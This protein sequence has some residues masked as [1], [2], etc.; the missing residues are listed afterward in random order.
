VEFTTAGKEIKQ[1]NP[2]TTIEDVYEDLKN[3]FGEIVEF[4]QED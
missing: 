1:V 2:K 3:E 4:K